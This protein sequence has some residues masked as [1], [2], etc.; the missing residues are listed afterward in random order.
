MGSLRLSQR[1]DLAARKA[2]G[3]SDRG[4]A[5]RQASVIRERQPLTR[6]VRPTALARRMHDGRP[7]GA[8]CIG[9]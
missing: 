8:A 7:G 5:H 4:Q 9:N 2:R 3:A 6:G 1:P